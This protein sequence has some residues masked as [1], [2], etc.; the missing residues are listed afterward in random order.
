V[1]RLD[2][3]VP[4]WEV[5]QSYV[6]SLYPGMRFQTAGVCEKPNWGIRTQT[7]LA[8]GQCSNFDSFRQKIEIWLKS[9]VTISFF[10]AEIDLKCCQYCQYFL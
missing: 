3:F 4:W 5:Y 10:S 7:W 2:L 1:G 6:G 9:N 8:R